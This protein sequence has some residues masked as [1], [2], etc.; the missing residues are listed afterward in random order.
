MRLLLL[1]LL[2]AC[3][4]PSGS[5][6]APLADPEPPVVPALPT[7]SGPTA[8]LRHALDPVLADLSAV[9]PDL[10]AALSSAAALL[11]LRTRVIL[12]DHR[13]AL[14]SAL[15]ELPDVWSP[16]ALRGLEAAWSA[17]WPTPSADELDA[18]EA[19][20]DA[21]L[22]PLRRRDL[23][24]S[25]GALTHAL[26]DRA[27]HGWARRRDTDVPAPPPDVTRPRNEPWKAA[28]VERAAVLF[29]RSPLYVRRLD[30]VP[31]T[32]Y[33]LE[34]TA[35]GVGR[36]PLGDRPIRQ[37]RVPGQVWPAS[38]QAWPDGQAMLPTEHALRVPDGLH[39]ATWS[40][41]LLQDADVDRWHATGRTVHRWRRDLQD[42]LHAL[43]AAGGD[44]ERVM[45]EIASAT[46]DFFG[47]VQPLLDE[48]A[49]EWLAASWR[50]VYVTHTTTFGEG[51]DVLSWVRVQ[52]A[53]AGRDPVPL[54]LWSGSPGAWQAPFDAGNQ[55][56]PDVVSWAGASIDPDRMPYEAL[57]IDP[58]SPDGPVRWHGPEAGLGV[59]VPAAH[60][61][62]DGDGSL[63]LYGR[64]SGE[65]ALAVA[66]HVRWV[67]A[68]R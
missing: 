27:R 59:R 29:D 17:R 56:E 31:G 62:P 4:R 25:D 60:P 38:G 2:T 3:T 14:L 32:L 7:H 63:P 44:R 57:M 47:D 67:D 9:D 50:T 10:A 13:P 20:L 12:A 48:L 40:L 19:E 52:V 26:L 21:R 55:F 36:S 28:Y 18:A 22:E 1:V 49:A 8:L 6:P 45:D 37:D 16:A 41:Q 39:V 30:D 43:L 33:A 54:L 24:D 66:A 15:A 11:D 64:T 61:D 68:A 35:T 34:T 46:G 58:A 42:D 51:Q 5:S 53:H 65:A 23:L